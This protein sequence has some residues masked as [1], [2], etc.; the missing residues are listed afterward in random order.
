MMRWWWYLYFKLTI[1][2]NFSHYTLFI[3]VIYNFNFLLSKLIAQ[4]SEVKNTQKKYSILGV[5]LHSCLRCMPFHVPLQL[6]TLF[7]SVIALSASNWF[8]PSVQKHVSPQ[9]TWTS[10]S[11]A[12]LVACKGFFSSM[13]HHVSFEMT[14]NVAWIDTLT[15][16]EMLLSWMC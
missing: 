7:A 8:L 15:T 12:T 10:E 11:E 2:N 14:S 13:L 6:D 16:D 9:M 3:A 5:F 1:P 4:D